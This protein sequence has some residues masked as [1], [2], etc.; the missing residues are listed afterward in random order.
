MFIAFA[1]AVV[2]IILRFVLPAGTPRIRVSKGG[3]PA[4]AIAVLEKIR[5]GG[6]DQWILE[7]S[8]NTDNPILLYLHGGPGTSQLTSNRRDTKDL[9]KS[10]IVVNWDQRGAGKSYD[11]IHDA[12]KMTIDQFV[13]DTK[14]LTLY[15]LKKF[16]KDRIILA[17]HS[18]G[19]LIGAM[20]VSRYPNLFYCYIGIGQV[21]RM[22]ENECASYEWT[23]QQAILKKDTR[24]IAKLKRIGPPPYQGDW[25]RK[26]LTQ[27]QLL[28]RFGGEIYGSSLG[29]FGLV[30]GGLLFS[31]EYTFIDR[32]NFF[33][34]IFG[35]MKLLWPQLMTVDLFKTVT[36]F[37]IP[38]YLMEGRHD[39]ESP[40]EIA[41]RYFQA[42]CA[43]AKELIWFERSA[44][45]PN[46][47]EKDKFNRIMVERIRPS[48]K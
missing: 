23:L 1:V 8:E 26:T 34:G 35:S 5:I 30:I 28:A 6:S 40:S 18:W 3:D 10:F 47:E 13:D 37:A 42:I 45:L 32:I 27:R 22:E 39:K 4:K 38:V 14:E 24:A 12:G 15:L 48:I 25:Q 11:A 46:S 17:G 43:P 41:E 9:E 31:R 16:G 21:A 2:I 7:R 19:S 20:T 29:A 33:K 44:H 36:E